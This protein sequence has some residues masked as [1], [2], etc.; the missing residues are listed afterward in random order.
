MSIESQFDPVRVFTNLD[1]YNWQVD[2]RPLEDLEGNMSTLAQ[3]SDA[4]LDATKMAA[5]AAG[6]VARG[7]AKDNMFV[8]TLTYPG[9]LNLVIDH[10]FLVQSLQASAVPPIDL[11]L[12]PHLGLQQQAKTFVG[13]VDLQAPSTVGNRNLYTIQARK[14]A[15]NSTISHYD[16]TNPH[17][18]DATVVGTVQFSLLVVEKTP[19]DLTDDYPLP[20][21]GW[22]SLLHIKIENG[23]SE[24]SSGLV[25]FDNFILDG[26]IKDTSEYEVY[27][28]SK[29]DVTII[30][31]V[32]SQ[33]TSITVDAQD[34]L[35]FIQGVYQNPSKYTIV[36]ESEIVW[37]GII[38]DDTVIDF[39]VLKSGTSST[40]GGDGVYDYTVESFIAG[41]SFPFTADGSTVRVDPFA[42]VGA[43][44][45][46]TVE[47]TGSTGAVIPPGTYTIVTVTDTFIEFTAPIAGSGTV[48]FYVTGYPVGQQLFGPTSNVDVDYSF[49]FVNGTF[50]PSSVPHTFSQTI[51][52]PEPVPPGAIVDLAVTLG[53]IASGGIPSGALPGQIFRNTNSGNEWSYP[54]RTLTL[55]SITT[56]NSSATTLVCTADFDEATEL[57]DGMRMRLSGFR[58]TGDY[59]GNKNTDNVTIQVGSTIFSVKRP[60]GGDLLVDDLYDGAILSYNATDLSLELFSPAATDRTFGICTGNI[61][62]NQVAVLPLQPIFNL[63]SGLQLTFSLPGVSG[64]STSSSVILDLTTEGVGGPTVSKVIRRA[65]GSNLISGDMVAGQ[66]VTVQYDGFLDL[67][68][69]MNPVVQSS[70]EQ[71]DRAWARRQT[72]L[73]GPR[74]YNGERQNDFGNNSAYYNSVSFLS[75]R[76]HLIQVCDSGGTPLSSELSGDYFCINSSEPNVPGSPSSVLYDTGQAYASF[77]AGFDASGPIE[78]IEALPNSTAFSKAAISTAL[79]GGYCGASGTDVI[80]ITRIGDL[81]VT[82]SVNHGFQAGDWV[83]ITGTN[84]KWVNGSAQVT[85]APSAN[86][87]SATS[88]VSDPF[89]SKTV[90]GLSTWAV[91]G[92]VFI[93]ADRNPSTGAI[94]YGYCRRKPAYVS[95]KVV[96]FNSD[97]SSLGLEALMKLSGQHVFNTDTYKMTVGN[98]STYSEVQRVFI[99]EVYL[100]D[101]GDPM[102]NSQMCTYAYNGEEEIRMR[103]SGTGGLPASGYVGRVNTGMG[104]SLYSIDSSFVYDYISGGISSEPESFS[105][106]ETVPDQLYFYYQKVVSCPVSSGGGGIPET[107]TVCASI[108]AKDSTDLRILRWGSA[109]TFT[110]INQEGDS[111]SIPYDYILWCLKLRRDF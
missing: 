37:D 65:G 24:L 14:V 61:T 100:G 97:S 1:P 74:W 27:T 93:Y 78:Y 105:S 47:V 39:V 106:S 22:V 96:P 102:Y 43:T 26:A 56:N 53:G 48:D 79:F 16:Q 103:V 63:Y 90:S 9:G 75:F 49:V 29:P 23:V 34:A 91:S 6:F 86:Q 59:I 98:G 73:K 35:V 25:T 83:N 81:T 99:G 104:T 60:R 67:W 40:V 84:R 2:N 69:L 82:T 54:L 85:F 10:G 72:V 110:Y 94:T 89:A 58:V 64:T 18:A 57:Y 12:Y 33:I 21:A 17:M 45:G 8:G 71:F 44:L 101:P 42:H 95:G 5:M 38:P 70:T 32:N 50:Q 15:A 52:L 20:T 41:G 88:Y 13:G 46:A 92:T 3:Y 77:S 109:T 30:D 66:S 11:K 68:V 51:L 36:S 108:V 107:S 111:T 19:S 76:P 62:T 31:G 87:F 7:F 55:S 4:T 28:V 80:G